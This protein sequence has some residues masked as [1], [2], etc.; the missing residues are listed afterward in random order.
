M[1]IDPLSLLY[2]SRRGVNTLSETAIKSAEFVSAGGNYVNLATNLRI[3]RDGRWRTRY[4]WR[5]LKFSGDEE[6][7]TSP[8]QGMIQYQPK[9]GAGV[10]YIGGKKDGLVESACGQL[11]SI[12]ISGDE[13]CVENVSCGNQEGVN[14]RVAWLSQAE[15]YVIRTDKS[16]R[17]QIWD[18]NNCS[19]FS[20]GFSTDELTASIPNG[21]G[22]TAYAD[23]ILWSSIFDR[24][25]L[26]SDRLGAFSGGATELLSYAQ[27]AL[28]FSSTTFT[29]PTSIGQ[30]IVAM[31][32]YFN[33]QSG[34]SDGTPYLMVAMQDGGMWG[35]RLGVPR[36]EWDDTQMVRPFSFESAPVGPYAWSNYDGELVY[37]SKRGI[38]SLVTLGNEKSNPFGAHPDLSASIECLFE[39]DRE[40]LLILASL[41]NSAQ[42]G[43]MYTTVSP[44][45]NGSLHWHDAYV[46]AKW[47]PNGTIYAGNHA[48][49]GLQ[50]LPEEMGKVVQFIEGTFNGIQKLYALTVDPDTGKKRL[51]EHSTSEGP[52]ILADGTEIPIGWKVQTKR[53]QEHG[54]SEL[55][56]S[57]HGTVSLGLYDIKE[58]YGYRVHK[59]TEVQC[60]WDNIGQSDTCQE[61]DYD[62]KCGGR[63]GWQD[64]VPLGRLDT[65]TKS[66]WIQFVIEGYGVGSIDLL[67]GKSSKGSSEDECSR[68]PK[69]KGKCSLC[70]FDPY[71]YYRKENGE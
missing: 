50:V 54:S 32:P 1:S 49:E 23:E 29:Q 18:G 58:D 17:A 13:F 44:N 36:D 26:G 10:H 5:E 16:S 15:N 65:T 35:I 69:A 42:F 25:V 31:F 7:L 28:A 70:D 21:G 67:L 46:S 45:V 34:S 40:D 33:S 56:P 47:N 71:E 3:S 57:E 6:W 22:P 9:Q 39:G 14:Y 38:E 60:T 59:R 52:D 55:L 30:C 4:P 48:W 24:E 8:T 53:I 66:S 19:V 64:L 43:R 51:L 11:W 63:S 61:C 27:Q 68:E 41:V 37:R 20:T 12:D 62:L 2:P